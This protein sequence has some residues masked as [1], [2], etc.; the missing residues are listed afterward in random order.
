MTRRYTRLCE[1]E[2]D[3]ELKALQKLTPDQL[4][5]LIINLEEELFK[6]N[7]ICKVKLTEYNA[8]TSKSRQTE[9]K[10]DRLKKRLRTLLMPRVQKEPVINLYSD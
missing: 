6:I 4:A 10:A 8:L 5:H 2:A 1:K 3:A 9:Y 7:E